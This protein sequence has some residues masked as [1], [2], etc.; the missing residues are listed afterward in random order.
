MKEVF[1]LDFRIKT[2][3]N[4]NS[5]KTTKILTWWTE[6]LFWCRWI[7][8]KKCSSLIA[9]ICYF[10]WIL[11]VSNHRN[12]QQK[13]KCLLIYIYRFC[14]GYVSLSISLFLTNIKIFNLSNFA[15]EYIFYLILIKLL[16][17]NN[18]PK[19]SLSLLNVPYN[20]I[21]CYIFMFI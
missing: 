3:F 13:I 11:L 20:F 21:F 5:F 19:Q 16:I 9:E 4:W 17:K 1:F 2:I 12:Q 15:F 10:C 8:C 14:D 6:Q 7:Q 18:N